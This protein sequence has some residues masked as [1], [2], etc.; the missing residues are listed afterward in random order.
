M[1][2]ASFAPGDYVLLKQEPKHTLQPMLSG[3]H[4]YTAENVLKKRRCQDGAVRQMPGGIS[5]QVHGGSSSGTP[6]RF[7]DLP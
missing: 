1:P 4:R 3:G 7:L 6:H 5:P 2:K